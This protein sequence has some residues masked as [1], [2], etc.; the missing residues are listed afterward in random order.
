MVT[1]PDALWNDPPVALPG[2]TWRYCLRPLEWF[3]MPLVGKLSGA[4]CHFL[5]GHLAAFPTTLFNFHGICHEPINADGRTP[6]NAEFG[7]V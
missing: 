6:C 4:A 1:W 7:S 2:A 3:G 5:G